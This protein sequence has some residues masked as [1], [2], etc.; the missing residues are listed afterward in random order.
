MIDNAGNIKKL[1]YLQVYQ[2]PRIQCSVVMHQD[3]FYSRE[4]LAMGDPNTL[5]EVDEKSPY[6]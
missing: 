4:R 3:I 1:N 2:T 6:E 5:I